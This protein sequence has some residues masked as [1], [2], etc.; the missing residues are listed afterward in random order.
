MASADAVDLDQRH[1]ELADGAEILMPANT[2]RA[3]GS[4]AELRAAG[5]RGMQGRREPV[6]V[7][8]PAALGV[9]D[10]L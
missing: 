7:S 3:L 8:R 5:I 9:E 1:E 2:A 10:S 6:E 4:I